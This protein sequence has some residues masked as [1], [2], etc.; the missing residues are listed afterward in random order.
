MVL[1]GRFLLKDRAS[2][3]GAVQW[4]L[5]ATACSRYREG[6]WNGCYSYVHEVYNGWVCNAHKLTMDDLVDSQKRRLRITLSLCTTHWQ[7]PF[8]S[9]LLEALLCS[10]DSRLGKPRRDS[11]SHVCW[12]VLQNSWKDVEHTSLVGLYALQICSCFHKLRPPCCQL[13]FHDRYT[14]TLI[15]N[16]GA[17]SAAERPCK[18]IFRW[19]NKSHTASDP[20]LA[21][22]K[23]GMAAWA[24]PLAACWCSPA[25]LWCSYPYHQNQ[26]RLVSIQGA[27]TTAYTNSRA[28]TQTKWLKMTAWETL[29]FRTF[30]AVMSG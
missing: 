14:K 2:S 8:L 11:L 25:L 23:I 9:P 28:G 10:D 17:H 1:R 24:R 12:S 21:T 27:Q 26:C 16:G 29:W 5:A 15:Q 4:R 30:W 19:S 13:L 20:A 3:G 18:P 7:K 6:M 22:R